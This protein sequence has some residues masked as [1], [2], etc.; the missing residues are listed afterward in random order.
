MNLISTPSL[1]QYILTP[2][3]YIEDRLGTNYDEVKCN[4]FRSTITNLKSSL[5]WKKY[6]KYIIG[7]LKSWKLT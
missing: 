1:L 5:I 3:I 2:N 7:Q 6:S 4:L